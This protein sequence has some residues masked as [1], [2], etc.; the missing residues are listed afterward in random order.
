MDAGSKFLEST[1]TA[2]YKKMQACQA[3]EMKSTS[4]FGV[5]YSNLSVLL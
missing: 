1:F 4:L 3:S 5:I 2:L